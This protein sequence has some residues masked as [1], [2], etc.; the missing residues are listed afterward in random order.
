MGAGA[1]VEMAGSVPFLGHSFIIWDRTLGDPGH[2]GIP[3]RK[4]NG[5]LGGSW[6][7]PFLIPFPRSVDLSNMTAVYP[8]RVDPPLRFAPQ[9]G[10][11]D[12][13]DPRS[14]TLSQGVVSEGE[15]EGYIGGVVPCIDASVLG[16][17]GSPLMGK[18]EGSSQVSMSKRLLPQLR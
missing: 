3:A 12:S 2:L 9:P 15:G 11:L 1:S 10:I 8:K 5:K 18:S 16:E 13:L 6:S 4:F 17:I 7:F 14:P